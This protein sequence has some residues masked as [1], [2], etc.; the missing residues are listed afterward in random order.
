MQQLSAKA[1]ELWDEHTKALA[2]D[3]ARTEDPMDV[4]PH[5]GVK[6]SAGE[7]AVSR[8]EKEAI[9]RQGLL[10]EDGDL[11]TPFRRL[12]L[13]MD[14]WC[15]LWFWPIT[16][17]A[18]LPSREEWWV[19]VGAILEGNV[20]DIT[21]QPGLDLGAAR[22]EPVRE[23]APK[24]Q[25]SFSAFEL[26]PPLPI[27]ADP[28]RLHDKLGQLRISRLR[29]HF[30]RVA[31][32]EDIASKRRFMHWDLCFADTVLMRG[33]FDLILGNPPWL[34]VEW[35]ESGV[36]G[37]GNPIF[38]IRRVSASDLTKLR[39]DAF[40]DFSGM[41]SV[42][43]EELEE[44]E[45][46]Q[47]FL[48]SIQNYPVLTGMQTNLYKCFLPVAWRLC[49]RYG[50]AGLLHPEGPY[51]DPKGGALRSAI[52]SR[53][54]T[55]FQFVNVK[56]L[57]HE[58]LHWVR[59]SINIYGPSN[60]NPNFDSISNLFVPTT[61]GACYQDG[62]DALAGGIKNEAGDWNVTG[63]KDRIISVDTDSLAVFAQLY[64]E[65][66]TDPKAAR[67]PTLHT[68]ILKRVLT[69][70]AN[71]PQKLEDLGGQY[72]STVMF[73]ESYAQRDGTITRRADSN[74]GFAETPEDWIVSGP[75][76][77][78]ATPF[79]KSPRKICSSH[80]GYDSIDLFSLPDFY[81]PRTNYI[82]MRDRTEYRRRMPRVCWVDDEQ[83]TPQPVASYFRHVHRRALSPNMERTTMGIIL[84]P[85]S[86]HIDGCFSI[87]FRRSTNLV[88]YSAA[89]AALPIDFLVKSTGKTDMRG[90]LSD[91][92]PL[93]VSG[94]AL[95]SRY[96]ALN[97]LTTHYTPLWEEVYD[98][99]FADQQWS[100][101]DNPRLPQ[102][103]W[104][105]LT[106]TWTRHCALRSD[107]ARRMA[108]VEIDVLVAQALGLTLEELLLIYRVQFPVMQ[109][110]ERDTWYDIAGRI[111]FT[112]SKGLV[113]VGLPRKGSRATPK[114]RIRTPDGKTREGNF[115]WEDLYKD[116]TFLVP[117][118]TVVTQW[119]IDDTLPGGPRTVERTYTTPFARANREDDYR[120]AWAF[121]QS[122]DQIG[123]AA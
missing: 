69:K 52:Y 76:F 89:L 119:V 91:K 44:A 41:Q 111:V 6:P 25:A 107:Y 109:G 79:Y 82:P 17:S 29:D 94:P 35:N 13:V 20:V 117:D 123:A 71:V 47:N 21:V 85:G 112:I 98:L 42:W 4:W 57:F 37:E 67:L 9:R 54:R 46:T 12:K 2:R 63:H 33:G 90:D 84:P 116:G 8:A 7:R 72:S 5:R 97:C 121:F 78:V 114:T 75:H 70:L 59:Y 77:F 62:G 45:G 32:V 66:G 60:E 23:L 108:L 53:L 36:L 118:G 73:D 110:Y 102:E 26:Q 56:K 68:G 87:A 99:A 92:L 93:L 86:A 74:A 34:K 113:G 30:P 61:I 1:Q 18:T 27:A 100:Q 122:A 105:D 80:L 101:P 65:P 58:V 104:Q 83:V 64:D 40:R 106:S 11:A 96:L 39:T 28:P 3:R 43:T 24:A 50:V 95:S 88:A 49:G 81:L 15:V 55:H 115:G 22:P 14:Y 10:N 103:F 31:L 38:A 51:D 48:S 120:T 19:E 16:G